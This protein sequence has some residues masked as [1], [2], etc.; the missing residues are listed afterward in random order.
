[1]ITL[2]PL[3]HIAKPIVPKDSPATDAPQEK[4][5]RKKVDASTWITIKKGRITPSIIKMMPKPSRKWGEFINHLLLCAS[6]PLLQRH[7][8]LRSAR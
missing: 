3:D 1:M 4:K 2:L 5:F 8:S 7:S 6:S